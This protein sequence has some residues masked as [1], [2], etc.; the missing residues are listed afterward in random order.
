MED[1]MKKLILATAASC[2]LATPALADDGDWTGAY[3]GV[4]VGYTG[5][6]SDSAVALSGSWTTESAALQSEVVNRWA[7]SQSLDDVNFGGQ[8]GYN[9][10]T[11]GAVLGIEADITALSG[12]EVLSRNQASTAF[13]ALNYTYTNRVDPKYMIS[14]KARLGAAMGNTLIYA[15]GGW[16]FTKADLGADILSNGGYSK[17][18]RLSK[19][20]DGFVV[21]AGLEHKFTDSVSARISYDYADMGDESY[22]TAYNAGSSFAPPTFNYVETFTQDLRMHL[23]KVGLNFHF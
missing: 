19:T 20:M 15:E 5:A 16:G 2:A 6:K 21:G 8:I 3:V 13:P 17:S 22:V 14:L 9:Y 11:G 23:V 7:A 12:N 18:G 10:Q 4:S 1:I